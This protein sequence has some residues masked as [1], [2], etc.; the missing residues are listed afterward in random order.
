MRF[1]LKPAK[2]F[3]KAKKMVTKS[4]E[5]RSQVKAPNQSVAATTSNGKKASSENDERQETLGL[6]WTDPLEEVKESAF[7]SSVQ[8]TKQY[9]SRKS[10]S[11][12]PTRNGSQA[13]TGAVKS[14]TKDTD[15]IVRNL[16]K[17]VQLL[18]KENKQLAK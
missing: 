18:S 16:A 1:D 8:D 15:S 17:Q 14:E 4:N 7:V 3:P 9:A 11:Q 12:T 6:S 5:P 10:E 13:A 2:L